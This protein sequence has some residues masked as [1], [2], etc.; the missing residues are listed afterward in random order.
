MKN[1][2]YLKCIAVAIVVLSVGGCKLFK[3]PMKKENKN[4]PSA[5]NDSSSQDSTNTADIQWRNYFSDPNL[6]A[7][8][9]TALKNNQELNITMQEIASA[10][11]DVK[12]KKGAYLPFIG[13]GANVG[14]DKSGYNTR[15]GAVDDYMK[16]QGSLKN[17][18]ATGNFMIGPM[19]SWELDIWKKLRNAKKAAAYRYLGTIEGKNFM[20]TKLVSE[21][22]SAYYELEGLDNQLQI[23]QQNIEI[24][25]SVLGIIKQQKD[26]AKVSQLAVNRFE[27]QLL[28]T[29]NRQYQIQQEIVVTEN[30]IN[31]L[32]GRFP[33]PIARNSATFNT[34]AFSSVFAGIPS[35]LLQNRPDIR[36]AEQQLAAAKLDVKVA[37]AEFFPSIHL[38]AAVGFQA[39]NPAVWFN[40][41]SLLYGVFG[42]IFAP[43]IN[44]N[45]IVAGYNISRAKQYQAVYNYEKTILNAFLEVQNQLSAV[46]KYSKSFDTKTKEVEILN[47]SITIS[48]S[49]FRN[50][51]ADYMEVL[52]TQREA[53]EQKMQ[54]VEIRTTQL[55]SEINIYKALGGGWK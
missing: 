27:A 31:F 36:Q 10:Q 47:Q 37:K 11:M 45:A 40:P 2:V 26:A 14:V 20:V 32:T 38:S 8:I 35:Q 29:Q 12:A 41:A 25:Q 24:Q 3:Q 22:A 42:D 1:R 49:L 19:L 33:Q 21:I 23:I 16:S 15:D 34:V 7:L 4:T 48:N 13:I 50:A 5:Y 43:L 18:N 53:L 6:I 28:N 17:V 52:L 55:Q 51:R 54:L 9:D 30:R 46:D 39:I 44:R